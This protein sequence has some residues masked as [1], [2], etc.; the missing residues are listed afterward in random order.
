M[1]GLKQHIIDHPEDIPLVRKEA[2]ETLEF[3]KYCEHIQQLRKYEDWGKFDWALMCSWANVVDAPFVDLMLSLSK[4][5]YHYNDISMHRWWRRIKAVNQRNLIR[6]FTYI[7]FTE[8][9]NITWEDVYRQCCTS[10]EIFSQMSAV[11]K[12][13]KSVEMNLRALLGIGQA[14]DIKTAWVKFAKEHH[15]D[16]GGSVDK[17]IVVKSAYEEWQHAHN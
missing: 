8:E 12:D 15:P 10:S 17:F 14:T 13:D 7:N 9:K 5:G 1:F 2:R 4:H 3:I 11:Y 6:F 16:K